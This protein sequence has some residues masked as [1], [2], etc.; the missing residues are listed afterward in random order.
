MRSALA[1]LIVLGGC[2]TAAV[3]AEGRCH[4]GAWRLDDG[5][6]LD[7]MILEQ[8]LR[9][10][11]ED[12]R[13]GLIR[14]K[15]GE[16]RS[17]LGWTGRP[18][19]H[20]ITFGACEAPALTFDGISATR[21][22]FSI[23]ETH[24]TGAGE[25]LFGRLLLP[26][27]EEAVPVVVQVHGSGSY[28][29]TAYNS[30][31]RMLPAQGI[32]VFVYDKRG[33]G[34]STGTY[35]QD[36]HVLAADAAAAAREARK[37]AGPRISSLVYEGISQGGW[38][39][40]LAATLEPADRII[41]GYG[42]TVSPLEE[43][44]SEVLLNVAE[45]GYGSD[46]LSGAAELADA[47]GEIMASNF[48]NGFDRLAEVKSKYKREPW[49]KSAQGE[50]TGEIL[51]YPVWLLRTAAPIARRMSDRGTTW[52]HEPLPVLRS[53]DVPVLWVL[54]GADRE[55]PP[56]Q[57][58]IDLIMLKRESK[59]I[60]VLEFPDTDHGMVEFETDS[61]GA[62]INTRV[63]EGYLA[64]IVDFARDGALGPGPYGRAEQIGD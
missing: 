28:S 35:T 17:S 58:R 55:A 10:R 21:L 30:R 49:F 3:P 25:T 60:T 33:T 62:R 48:R 63:T 24:F 61:K 44:K 26:E 13:T 8:G 37:L 40:P 12:G 46:A 45:A 64:A 7:V 53:L 9:W 41:V 54:A 32:G 31:Q 6:I 16:P 1:A 36:F 11:L 51:G 15:E 52:R 47:T 14:M 42:L 18:D 22:S 27:G 38:V 5:R 43:N 19:A 2:S 34:Q 29:D 59:P 20:Q 39:A 4:S 50:F 23:Q 56:E 57:T